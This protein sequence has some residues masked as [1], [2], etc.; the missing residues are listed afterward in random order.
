MCKTDTKKKRKKY[1][2]PSQGLLE[3]SSLEPGLQYVTKLPKT[4]VYFLFAQQGKEAFRGKK[5]KKAIVNNLK[6]VS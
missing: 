1:S 3:Y 2:Q 6:Q 5:K 4:S